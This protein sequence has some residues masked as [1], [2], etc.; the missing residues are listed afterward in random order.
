MGNFS[1]DL[2]NINLDDTNYDEDDFKT[3]KILASHNKFEKC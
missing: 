1:V 2:K 3:I